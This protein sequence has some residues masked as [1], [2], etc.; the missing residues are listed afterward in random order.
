MLQTSNSVI[1]LLGLHNFTYVR[2][3]RYST[4]SV[5]DERVGNPTTGTWPDSVTPV[6]SPETPEIKVF[7]NLIG[8]G[9][10][11]VL[12]VLVPGSALSA[13][14]S[15]WPEPPPF[16]ALYRPDHDLLCRVDGSSSW[17]N[18]PIL[19]I[20]SYSTNATS[21][22]VDS[23]SPASRQIHNMYTNTSTLQPQPVVDM[24]SDPLQESLIYEER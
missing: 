5:I 21:R 8:T 13:A 2:P 18:V 4:C 9:K 1:N 16:G 11:H 20:H 3:I 14:L 12:H 6:L 19:S 10:C 24:L 23:P 7:F 22:A 15:I 17:K